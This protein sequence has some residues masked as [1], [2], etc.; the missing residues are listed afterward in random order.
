[1]IKKKEYQEPTYQIIKV[2][3]KLSLLDDSVPADDPHPH[4]RHNDMD[5]MDDY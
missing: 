1:M 4:A 3:S 2:R 5:D